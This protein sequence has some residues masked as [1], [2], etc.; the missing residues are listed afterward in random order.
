MDKKVIKIKIGDIGFKPAYPY[1]KFIRTSIN[2][3]NHDK[4]VEISPTYLKYSHIYMYRQII[5]YR[6]FWNECPGWTWT[7]GRK[8]NVQLR[9]KHPGNANPMTAALK[10]SYKGH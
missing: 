3:Q 1:R 4:M 5:I 2:P 7:I 9:V 10:N 6:H 8:R